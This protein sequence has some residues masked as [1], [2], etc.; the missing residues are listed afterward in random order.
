MIQRIQSVYLF[1]TTLLSILFLN[2]SFLNFINKT[3]VITKL[4]FKGIEEGSSA[5]GFI[6]IERL[7]PLSIVLLLIAVI[8]LFTIFFFK[9]RKVQIWLSG[10]LIGL[11]IFLILACGHSSYLIMTKYS[12][13]I[14]PGIKMVL[15]FLMLLF[16][17]LAYRGIRKDEN[18]VKS[19]DRLR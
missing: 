18:L 16:S 9:K 6:L 5:Q 2:G 4:T 3:G 8:S 1:L 12:S 19:Y 17:I 14:V 10:I 11:V 7:L 13:E 15:P